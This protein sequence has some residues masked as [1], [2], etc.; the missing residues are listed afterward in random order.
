MSELPSEEGKKTIVVS[1]HIPTFYNYPEKYRHSELNTAF[2]TELF[3]LIEVSNVDYWILPHVML[4]DLSLPPDE[5]RAFTG[6]EVTTALASRYP[7]I[8][9]IILSGH[10][11]ESFIAQ[12]IEHGAHGY[13]I[14]DCDPQEVYGAIQSAYTKGSYI[15]A[16]AVKAIVNRM[17]DKTKPKILLQES[18]LSDREIEVLQLICRQNTT[19]ELAEKLF[20]SLKT[21]NTHRNNLLMKT[22]AKNVAGLVVYAMKRGIADL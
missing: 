15:N 20:I 17:N 4:V 13:L 12:L 16:R 8:K 2:A 6:R 11:D 1:H 9:V 18:P 21:V 5:N 14:K 7:D 22:G 19:E 10:S 3:D